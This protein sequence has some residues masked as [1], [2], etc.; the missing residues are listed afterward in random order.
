MTDSEIS[1]RRLI[2]TQCQQLNQSGGVDEC[3][4]NA[5]K[6]VGRYKDGEIPLNTISPLCLKDGPCTPPPT[7]SKEY[8]ACLETPATIN[9]GYVCDSRFQDCV[10]QLPTSPLT[11]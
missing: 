1:L 6:A 2:T 10:A 11:Q 9:R 8:F 5:M 3:V 7:C 4:A